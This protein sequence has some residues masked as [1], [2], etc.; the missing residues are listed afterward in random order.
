MARVTDAAAAQ[1]IT[2]GDDAVAVGWYTMD[3]VVQVE[4]EQ[5][6]GTVAEV[7][8]LALGLHQAGLVAFGK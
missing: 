2:A 7:F 1:R 6:Y 3:E 4:K 5:D 8:G